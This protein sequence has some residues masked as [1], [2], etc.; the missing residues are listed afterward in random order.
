MAALL[1]DKEDPLVDVSSSQLADN[2]ASAVSLVNTA[3]AHDTSRKEEDPLAV[4]GLVDEE[5]SSQLTEDFASA[6]SL[7]NT[8]SLGAALSEAQQRRLYGLHM[9]ATRGLAPGSPPDGVHPEQFVAWRDAGSSS[10]EAAMEEYVGVVELAALEADDAEAVRSTGSAGAQSGKLDDLPA[11]L[12]DQL[13]AAG[14]IE[15][16]PPPSSGDVEEAAA[17]VFDAARRGGDAVKAF[18]QMAGG[19]WPATVL[20]LR[21]S[22]GL[23][24]LHHAVDAGQPSSVA[25]LLSANAAV[26]TVDAS[27][28]TPLHYA[29]MLDAPD[30]TKLLLDAGASTA[31]MDADG[32]VP[33]MLTKS[34]E[35]KDML[36]GANPETRSAKCDR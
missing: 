7:V 21:D 16:R 5:S 2:F 19:I 3:M 25:V 26:D 29:A 34:K 18:L 30:L 31:V 14:L 1:H 12:R 23:S 13:A 32:A 20:A 17:D 33:E 27:G 8:T 10:A 28:A 22:D 15:S 4:T 11:G 35:L 24:A 9:R 36:A 6:V